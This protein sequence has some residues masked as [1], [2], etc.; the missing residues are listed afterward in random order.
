MIAQPEA[1]QLDDDARFLLLALARETLRTSVQRQTTPDVQSCRLP[2]ALHQTSGCFVTL[3]RSGALRGCIGNV[4]PRW[5]LWQAVIENTRAAATRDM[6]FPPVTA[7]ELE[8]L[9]IEISVLSL[10][11]LLRHETPEALLAALQPGR[12]G[13]LLEC[14]ARHAT[15]LPQVWEKLPE[16][17]KFM[18]QLAVKAG[19]APRD[20]RRSDAM[21]QTYRV[22][23]FAEGDL[24]G[25]GV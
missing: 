16:P 12:D 25:G 11:A 21:V 15:F 1:P 22:A 24:P 14:A 8:A 3:T 17:A 20:W 5:P 4:E 7:G 2:P 13:V 19:L 6:R 18:S 10:P 23:H 9:E